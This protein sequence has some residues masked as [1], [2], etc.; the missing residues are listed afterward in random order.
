MRVKAARIAESLKLALFYWPDRPWPPVR[1]MTF[2]VTDNCIKCKYMDCVEVCPVDCFYEG[3]NM[4]VIH[5]DECIHCGVCEPE[6]PANAISRTPPPASRPGLS[7]TPTTPRPGPISHQRDPPAD[8]KEF[9]GVANKLEQF[10]SPIP[11]R[12][13][14]QQGAGETG[15]Y[16][17]RIA[18]RAARTGFLTPYQFAYCELGRSKSRKLCQD[19]VTSPADVAVQAAAQPRP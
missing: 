19:A 5:P 8:A 10:F 17:R 15:R 16:P 14:D 4:L 11:G 2:V 6:C 7:S 1:T 9:D 13:T 12:A 18:G 3:D